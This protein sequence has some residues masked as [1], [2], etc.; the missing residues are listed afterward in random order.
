M[1]TCKVCHKDKNQNQYYVTGRGMNRV[2]KSCLNTI[3]Q[4]YNVPNKGKTSL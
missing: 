3:Q 2:C 1:I 4:T